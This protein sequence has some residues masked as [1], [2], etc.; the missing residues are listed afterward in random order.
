M[1]NILFADTE[2]EV[3]NNTIQVHST[4]LDQVITI[5][6][7]IINWSALGMRPD[8]TIVLRYTIDRIFKD[9]VYSAAN[10]PDLYHLLGAIRTFYYSSIS[11]EDAENI[12]NESSDPTNKLLSTAIRAG[13][14]KTLV[15]ID[16]DIFFEGLVKDIS[17]TYFVLMGG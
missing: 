3:T 4:D 9:V 11:I 14:K 2:W 10:I 8:G 15:D 13:E 1:D 16:N 17:G 7:K 6:N 5:P 12:E